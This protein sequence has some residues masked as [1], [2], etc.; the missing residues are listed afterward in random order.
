MI[1]PEQIRPFFPPVIRDNPGF[2]KYMMK[3]YIQLQILD[4]LSDS[5]HARK[6]VF[7]GGTNLRLIKG[8]DRFS[9]DL[10]F[11]CKDYSEKEFNEMTADVVLFLK[12]LGLN[13]EVRD[14]KSE[15]IKAFRSSL[16]FPEFLFN[17]GLTGHRDER[18]LI[19]LECQDQHVRYKPH[20]VNI[21]GCGMFFPFPVPPDPVLYSMKI[22]A[23]LN[24]T[25][26]R[27]FYDVMFL[28][29]QAKPDYDFLAAR[30]GI[31]NESELKEELQSLLSRINLTQKSKDF[32]HLLVNRANSKRILGFS[33]FVETF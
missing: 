30:C 11:D 22:A 16:Y 33:E 18:F 13:P 32:E 17:L 27:D 3:E 23:L 12:R 24:R 20:L 5:A 21:K 2:Q 9:E 15:R 10:D 26:G 25:K 4:H 31:N 7:I 6:L 29:G 28:S 8:I 19:K 1:S 14:K